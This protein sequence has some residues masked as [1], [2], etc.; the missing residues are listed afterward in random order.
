MNSLIN[1]HLCETRNNLVEEIKLLSETQFNAKPDTKSWS[2]AQVCHHL[3]LTEESF[4]RVI[5]WGLKQ[6]ESKQTERKNVHL[7][8]DR[9]KKVPAPEIVE[10]A[11]DFFSVQQ[12]IGLLDDSRKKLT[13]M[14]DTIEDPSILAKKA[15]KHPV[16]GELPLD[17]WVEVIYIHE[18]RHIEQIKEIKA[19]IKVEN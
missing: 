16:F 15:F 12:I 3:T 13:T 7:I 6:E 18:Q 14:L 19:L 17:Q 11:E 2:I 10:P 8:A 5:S 9:T 4:V 1:D